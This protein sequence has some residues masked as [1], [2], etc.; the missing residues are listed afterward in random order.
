V[1]NARLFGGLASI[2]IVVALLVRAHVLPQADLEFT[3]GHGG[4]HLGF[5]ASYWEPLIF[6]VG[7][8]FALAYFGIAR[9]TQRPLNLTTGIIGFLLVALA[10][11][12]WLISSFLIADGSLRGDRLAILLF[13]AMGCFI[14]GMVLS[15]ANVVWGLLR[16]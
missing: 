6:L 5:G 13:A 16:K 3:V 11:V 8:F 15:A 9:L 4:E 12:A 14:L 7:A 10:S 2:V 1:L